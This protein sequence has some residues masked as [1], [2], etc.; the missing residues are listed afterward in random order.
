MDP[1]SSRV[2][3]SVKSPIENTAGTPNSGSGEFSGRELSLVIR[4]LAGRASEGAESFGQRILSIFGRVRLAQPEAP[5]VM[6]NQ[7][8]KRVFGSKVIADRIFRQLRTASATSCAKLIREL[9]AQHSGN[10]AEFK[11]TLKRMIS[12]DGI[13]QL[14]VNFKGLDEQ[15]QID[16]LDV[17]ETLNPELCDS[18]ELH[19]FVWDT[20]LSGSRGWGPLNARLQAFLRSDIAS[21]KLT[22]L[23]MKFWLLTTRGSPDPELIRGLKALRKIDFVCGSSNGRCV[24]LYKP[25]QPFDEVRLDFAFH[26]GPYRNL[27]TLKPVY[28]RA[29]RLILQGDCTF[30]LTDRHL[31]LIA[32]AKPA[33]VIIIA[34]DAPAPELVAAATASG[35]KVS[36]IQP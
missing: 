1:V 12:E 10:S 31:M 7:L 15:Q 36:F 27:V 18:I 4:R 29:S 13:R 8:W 35:L 28:E 32:E 5:R 3:P 9:A 30:G 2:Q 24:A 19:G 14:G 11:G 17:I 6:E 26:N 34:K 22:S 25:W 23:A 33:E 21:K 16:V 20:G